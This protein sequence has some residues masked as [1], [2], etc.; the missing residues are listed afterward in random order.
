MNASDAIIYQIATGE[1]TAILHK[2]KSPERGETAPHNDEVILSVTNANSGWTRYEVGKQEAVQPSA[3]GAAVGRVA[4][5][6]IQRVNVRALAW[7]DILAL[8]YADSLD[9]L[10]AW[11]LENDPVGAR[12]LER[13]IWQANEDE[14]VQSRLSQPRLILSPRPPL[15]Y[16]A[17]LVHFVEWQSDAEDIA[18]PE[19]NTEA[20]TAIQ[21]QFADLLY[22]SAEGVAETAKQAITTINF[23]GTMPP[24]AFLVTGSYSVGTPP[25]PSVD[26]VALVKEYLKGESFDARLVADS[27][28]GEIAVLYVPP[29]TGKGRIV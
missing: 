22:D 24:G 19:V 8:G 20:A 26:L 27:Q 28:T 29:A 4:V 11:C 14:T 23:H 3:S 21:T 7:Q 1:R 25:P 16:D 10:W 5:T 6:R 18:E 15:L 13:T 12:R 9:L 17:W 2:V